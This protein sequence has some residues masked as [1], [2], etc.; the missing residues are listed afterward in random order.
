ME[1]RIN[2]N[3]FKIHGKGPEEIAEVSYTIINNE[4][5]HLHDEDE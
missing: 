1:L 5:N 4:C 2:G 3:S